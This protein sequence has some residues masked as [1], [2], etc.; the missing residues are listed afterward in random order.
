MPI[1][2]DKGF[3]E[4]SLIAPLLIQAAIAQLKLIRDVGEMTEV[5]FYGTSRS[6][7][8]EDEY[9]QLVSQEPIMLPGNFYPSLKG[10][11]HL[12]T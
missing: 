2:H 10:S 1:W 3:G 12:R 4:E 11:K 8:D 5:F 6:V 7:D 9:G